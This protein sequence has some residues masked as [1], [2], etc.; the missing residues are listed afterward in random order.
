MSLALLPYRGCRCCD[1]VA[2]TPLFSS[3]S[4]SRTKQGFPEWVSPSVPPKYYLTNTLSGAL[5]LD[6]TDLPDGGTITYTVSGSQ[7][8]DR[9]TGEG[10]DDTNC[11]IAEAGYTPGPDTTYNTAPT[12][13]PCSAG[14]MGLDLSESPTVR[15]Y[16]A[17]DPGDSGSQNE[18]LSDENTTAQ[19]IADTLADIIQTVGFGT[20]QLPAFRDLDADELTFS[21]R[22]VIYKFR[23]PVPANGLC[24]RLAWTVRT[25]LDSGPVTDEE[26]TFTWDGGIPEDYDPDDPDTWPTSGEYAMNE[27][28]ANGTVE[29]VGVTATCSGCA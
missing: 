27:P 18:T 19:L 14:T 11:E 2:A 5:V 24:Y 3:Y 6:E 8:I 16:S 13:L 4:A 23:F 7:T 26:H 20:T 22:R 15:S 28:S 9:L 29:V 21:I 12:T 17:A 25:T 1:C 10:A